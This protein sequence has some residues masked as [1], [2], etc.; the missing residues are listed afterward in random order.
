[1]GERGDI[2]YLLYEVL[3]KVEAFEIGE[4]RKSLDF[5]DIISF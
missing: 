3:L 1:M 5:R 4:G 2:R